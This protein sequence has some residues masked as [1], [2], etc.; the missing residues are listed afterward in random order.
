MSQNPSYTRLFTA[1]TEIEKTVNGAYEAVP[2]HRDDLDEALQKI[3]DVARN[4]LEPEPLVMD[5]QTRSVEA[6]GQALGRADREVRDPLNYRHIDDFLDDPMIQFKHPELKYV[7]FFLAHARKSAS[8]RLMHE[9]F[10]QQFQLFA[11]Y[12]GKTYQITGASRLGDIWLTEDHK[13]G[14]QY[15]HRVEPDFRKFSNWRDKANWALSFDERM[16]LAKAAG[17]TGEPKRNQKAAD[18]L[19]NWMRSNAIPVWYCDATAE[20][21]T[22]LREAK[23][24]AAEEE[25]RRREDTNYRA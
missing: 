20:Q 6:N 15:S 22:T 24:A 17:C 16:I 21:R 23:I 11:D 8:D 25:R 9:P 18:Y 3:R 19:N 10:M 5:L 4:A 1:L 2:I 7:N 13:K 12:E 14:A